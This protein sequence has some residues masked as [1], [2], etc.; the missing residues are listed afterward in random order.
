MGKKQKYARKLY[1]S[2]GGVHDTYT[3]IFTS[4]LKSEA[5]KDLTSKE[6][7]VY[8][9]M[10]LQTVGTKKPRNDY[11]NIPDLQYEECIYFP[12]SLAEEFGLYSRNSRKEF[13]STIES[14]ES[15]GFIKKI[16]SGRNTRQKSI[17]KLSSDWIRW[18][19]EQS[20]TS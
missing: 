17:Y 4:M 13:Y 16:S 19:K 11:P 7:V 12:L 1:E 5:F 8:V 9:C 15:H 20:T 2:D 3:M 6:K 14:L 18:K 10:K